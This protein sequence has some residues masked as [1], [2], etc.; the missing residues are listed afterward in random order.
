MVA[1]KGR[2]TGVLRGALEWVIGPLER[3]SGAP[4]GLSGVPERIL[5]VTR[6]THRTQRPT[7]CSVSNAQK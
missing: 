6:G 7:G 5:G 1:G 2:T 4:E 3:L